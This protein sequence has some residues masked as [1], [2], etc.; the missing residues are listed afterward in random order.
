M[1]RQPYQKLNQPQRAPLQYFGPRESSASRLRRTRLGAE[2]PKVPGRRVS[3][4][5]PPPP[6][7]HDPQKP[8][9]IEKF[10][11]PLATFRSQ[12]KL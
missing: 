3:I 11:G 4:L 1:I 8:Q 7:A 2:C 10:P 12:Q 6:P 5:G 9:R